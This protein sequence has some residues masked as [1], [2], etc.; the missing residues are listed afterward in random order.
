MTP[1]VAL[2]GALLQA[3]PVWTEAPTLPLP[4]ANNA[5]AGLQTTDG[6]AVFSFLGI[7]STR[8]WNGRSSAV[9]RWDI[10]A[11]TWRTLRV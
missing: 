4:I 6:P 10:G 1:T 8:A 3:A 7:D 2:F 9:L 11:R 5:V